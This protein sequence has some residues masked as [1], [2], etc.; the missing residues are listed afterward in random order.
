MT[1][2][3]VILEVPGLVIALMIAEIYRRKQKQ[4]GNHSSLMTCFKEI[5]FGK[6]ILLLLG[7]LVIGYLS[8]QQGLEKIAPFFVDPFLGVLVLFML[9]MGLVAGERLDG[10]RTIKAFLI[11][12]AFIIPILN[13]FLGVCFGY[14]AGLSIGGTTVLAAMAASASYIAAPAVVR[15]SL[16][17][18]NPAYYLTS[19]IV[20]T[21]PFNLA[22]G[23]P[24]YYQ[25][26][27]WVFG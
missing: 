20:L 11:A 4:H 26:A 18:A 2:L 15:M 7:G 6:S 22:L 17:E 8:G 1:A 24:L 23:I 27:L 10:L 21:F 14:W 25:M 13:G 9:D 3:V 16:P 12:F 19:A 5:I